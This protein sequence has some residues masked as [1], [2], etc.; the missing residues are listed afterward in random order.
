LAVSP[1]KI[2]N[3]FTHF[4]DAVRLGE[5]RISTD[6]DC[7][8]DNICADPVQD[9]FIDKATKHPQYNNVKKINDIA[10]LRLKS[11]A[12]IAG[13]YVK[14][15]CL[16]TTKDSQIEAIEPVARSKMTI[17]GWGKIESG[18]TSDVL[19]KAYV[20]FVKHD[21]CVRKFA[22][23]N[24]SIYETYLCAGGQNKTDVS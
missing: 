24:L 18:K 20:P 13:K 21:Q 23:E 4:R 7:N 8:H 19:L 14:T 17:T 15:I 9:I 1:S 6:R 5:H 12:N 2:L 10:L 11:A 16:P 3:R 22:P